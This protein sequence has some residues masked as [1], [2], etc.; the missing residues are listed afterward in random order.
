MVISYWLPVAINNQLP[1]T[2]KKP[3]LAYLSLAGL[4]WAVGFDHRPKHKQPSQAREG[5]LDL[6]H[7]TTVGRVFMMVECEVLTDRIGG[8]IRGAPDLSN[9]RAAC[10]GARRTIFVK[11]YGSGGAHL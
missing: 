3:R 8:I 6:E 7:L 5:F 2:N 10:E 1:L 9:W 11:T 4:V